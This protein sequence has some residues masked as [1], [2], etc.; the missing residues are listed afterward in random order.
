[1]EKVGYRA[2]KKKSEF[3]LIKKKLG[4]EI[5]G[6]GIEPSEEK[7]EAII[8]LK[9]PETTKTF[10]LKQGDRNIKPIAYESIYSKETEKKL[11]R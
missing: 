9:P 4:H 1:M 8:K 6:D 7:M 5:D 11:T 2:N 10:W 3:F